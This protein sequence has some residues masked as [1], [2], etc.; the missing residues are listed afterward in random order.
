MKIRVTCK[1]EQGF[2]RGGRHWPKGQTEA[3]LDEATTRL[4]AAEPQLVVAIAK[5]D[6]WRVV[7][8]LPDAP[9]AQRE[10]VTE[11]DLLAMVERLR[12]Q[13]RQERE[14]FEGALSQVASDGSAGEVERADLAA[15]NARIQAL[16]AD[17]D[18]LRALPGPE[19]IGKVSSAIQVYPGSQEGTWG[20]SLYLGGRSFE[21]TAPLTQAEASALGDQLRAD[22]ARAIESLEDR[23]RQTFS[24]APSPRAAPGATRPHEVTVPKA[25][26]AAP[27][28]LAAPEAPVPA[29]AP[30][31]VPKPAE[32]PAP[33]P[34][35]K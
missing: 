34:A 19:S 8:A 5:S 30:E 10:V 21:V 35:K 6:G 23:L 24:S 27:S 12:A 2:W 25:Q 1:R 7:S 15:K 32:T 3:D 20:I 14:A 9:D 28:D 31:P 4:L 33:K 29:P 16:Q 17:L 11:A 18:A 22:I 13:I 26:A